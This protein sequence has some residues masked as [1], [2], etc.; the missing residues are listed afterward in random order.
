MVL[1]RD[2]E[3]FIGLHEHGVEYLVVG[4]YALACY[5]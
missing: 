1:A 4:G 5:G 2:F 3:E